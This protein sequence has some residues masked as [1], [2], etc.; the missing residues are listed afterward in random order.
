MIKDLFKLLL[1]VKEKILAKFVSLVPGDSIL[2][3]QETAFQNNLDACPILDINA[4]SA[5]L[6]CT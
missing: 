3:R 1:D 2:L 6:I 4:L 5:N